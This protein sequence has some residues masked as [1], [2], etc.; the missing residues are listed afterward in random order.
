M[1][2]HARIQTRPHKYL[3]ELWKIVRPPPPPP[4]PPFNNTVATGGR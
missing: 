1:G 3:N 2:G 4:P